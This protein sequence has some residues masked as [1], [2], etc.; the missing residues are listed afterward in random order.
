MTFLSSFVLQ[1]IYL[2]ADCRFP[3]K[4]Y[5]LTCLIP[6]VEERMKSTRIVSM[7]DLTSPEHEQERAS[8][9]L[10]AVVEGT[11]DAIFVKDIDGRFIMINPA[12]A[13]AIGRTV[14]EVIGKTTEE[15][16]DPEIAARLTADDMSVMAR[17]VPKVVESELPT[18][19]GA[20]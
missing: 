10:Q 9:I 14:D 1:M 6:P 2:F 5:N 19:Q 17:G 12:G 16:L 18:P 20:R 15:V 3:I 7:R 8:D 11:T 4:R 13:A